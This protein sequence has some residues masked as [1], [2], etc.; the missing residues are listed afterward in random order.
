MLDLLAEITDAAR[1]YYAQAQAGQLTATD[2][3]A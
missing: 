3:Y 2:F 1:A